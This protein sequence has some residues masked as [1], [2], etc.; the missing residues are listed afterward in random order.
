MGFC[1]EILLLF[2]LRTRVTGPKRLYPM[3]GQV[4]MVF[5]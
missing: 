4:A 3:L 5:A 2:Y 1:T